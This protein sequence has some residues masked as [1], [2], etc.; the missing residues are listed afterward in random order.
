MNQLVVSCLDLMNFDVRVMDCRRKIFNFRQAFSAPK[1][2][3]SII[4]S[5]NA[6]KLPIRSIVFSPICQ[7]LPRQ[8]NMIAQT[9]F[10][11]SIPNVLGKQKLLI[12]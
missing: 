8:K 10:K 9:S 1:I 4:P 12:A 11:G 7:P 6:K 2:Y 3:I 5:N